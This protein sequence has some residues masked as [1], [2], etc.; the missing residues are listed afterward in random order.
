MTCAL[1]KDCRRIAE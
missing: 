1:L